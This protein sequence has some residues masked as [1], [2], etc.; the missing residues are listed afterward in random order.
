MRTTDDFVFFW[1]DK[2]IY[3]NWYP[4]KFVVK[5]IVFD[6]C[7]Q[8]MMYQKAM[9]FGD[10]EIAAEILEATHPKEHKELGRKVRGFDGDIWDAHRMRIMTEGC[11]A[12]FRQNPL[13][14]EQ[15]LA[16][17][18]RQLVEASPY[19]KVWGIGMKENDPRATDPSQWQGLNLLGVALMKAR[20]NLRQSYES[21][22]SI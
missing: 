10:V 21:N 12:K 22:F 20:Q 9:L 13:L 3:S 11:E 4:S 18:N 6:C 19:D 5:N 8:Y 7:E 15:L 2:D 14:L 16:T 17:G 1:T